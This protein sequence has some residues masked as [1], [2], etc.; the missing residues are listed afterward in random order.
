MVAACQNTTGA[1]EKRASASGKTETAKGDRR[2]RSPTPSRHFSCVSS[3]TPLGFYIEAKT[4]PK[5][6]FFFLNRKYLENGWTKLRLDGRKSC[7]YRGSTDLWREIFSPP[8]GF[9]VTSVWTKKNVQKSLLFWPQYLEKLP[10]DR[11]ENLIRCYSI[12]LVFK[13]E[14]YGTFVKY[15]SRASAPKGCQ[16][17]KNAKKT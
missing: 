1:A 2:S 11:N 6:A 5:Y 12:L 14:N 15:E 7:G 9:F 10:T 13:T 4:T 8:Y 16:F 3:E 17:E